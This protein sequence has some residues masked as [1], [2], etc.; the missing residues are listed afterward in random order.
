MKYLPIAKTELRELV[1]DECL[2]VDKTAYVKMLLEDRHK[3]YFLSRPRRFG[4]TLF[5]DTLRAAFSGEKELFEGLFLE[6][7]WNWERHYPVLHIS[8]GRVG[9]KNAAE[10]NTFFQ[11]LFTDLALKFG[12]TVSGDFVFERFYSLLEQL[13]VKHGAPVVVLIDEYDKPLLDNLT[14]EHVND[15]RTELADFYSVLKDAGPFLKFVFLTGVSRFSKTSIFSKLN[16]LTD[17]SL[18]PKYADI[19]GITPG[20][21]ESVFVDFLHDVD[22]E[23]LRRWYNGYNFRGSQVYNPYDLLMFF[24]QKEY[25][26]YWF[27]TGTPTFLLKLIEQRKFYIPALEHLNISEAQMADFDIEHIE[28][29]VLLFQTGYLTIKAV[30]QIG[31]QNIYTLQLPNQE[32]RMGFNDYLLRMFYASAVNSYERTALAEQIYYA[33]ADGKPSELE[34]IFKSFFAAIPADWYR[35]NNIAEYEGF[36][37]SMFYA[38]FASIGL[39]LTAE[40]TSSKGRIDLTVFMGETVFLFEFKMKANP[41]NALQQI[42]DRKYYEKYIATA[43]DVYLIGIE[44]DEDAKNISAFEW[45]RLSLAQ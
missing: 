26:A 39:Q 22:R 20:E 31:S 43:T 24:W 14:G 4:K 42:R 38:V 1:E 12:V 41:Q 33:L 45:E 8:L 21:L 27:N 44:F 16:N 11:N 18:V 9:V 19:C 15:I 13:H 37:C 25:K 17:I 5:L 23:K 7:N 10:L 3:Y 32:V 36:Y 35:R 40:D 30:Q 28:L 34:R 29:D 2:Y 6:N